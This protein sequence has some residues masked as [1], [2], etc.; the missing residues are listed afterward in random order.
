MHLKAPR[1]C[2]RLGKCSKDRKQPVRCLRGKQA[3]DSGI[4]AV[5]WD[6]RH[7]KS[8]VDDGKAIAYLLNQTAARAFADIVPLRGRSS[9]AARFLRTIG[10]Q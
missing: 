5:F 9:L 1:R 2:R 3:R 10:H 6:D 7:C 4:G 8:A